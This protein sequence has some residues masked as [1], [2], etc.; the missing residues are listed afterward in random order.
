MLSVLLARTLYRIISSRKIFS[1]CQR[2]GFHIT[3]NHYYFPI[4]DT[5]KLKDNLW[6]KNSGLVG[7]DINEE[8]HM[9]R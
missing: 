9:N 6:S 7:V 3:P 8:K 5:T 1:L 4:P 2:F